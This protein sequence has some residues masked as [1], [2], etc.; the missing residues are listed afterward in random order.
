MNALRC[1]VPYL[2]V[3]TG[4]IQA[5][6]VHTALHARTSTHAHTQSGKQPGQTGFIREHN[7]HLLLSCLSKFHS[8]LWRPRAPLYTGKTVYRVCVTE[9][10]RYNPGMSVEMWQA[11]DAVVW[12]CTMYRML[13]GQDQQAVASREIFFSKTRIPT[14][15]VLIGRPCCSVFCFLSYQIAKWS[16]NNT[17]MRI[18]FP[19]PQPS[20][21]W[22]FIRLLTP[23]EWMTDDSIHTFNLIRLVIKLKSSYITDISSLQR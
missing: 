18:K 5:C 15:Y 3:R 16:G 1:I 22:S 21:N 23:T 10:H 8:A 6:K 11:R 7:H 9:N 2:M 12:P 20:H 17:L 4:G 14:L 19:K 13:E